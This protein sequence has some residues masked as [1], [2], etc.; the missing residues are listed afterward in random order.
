MDITPFDYCGKT[1]SVYVKDDGTIWFCGNEVCRILGLINPRT[2]ISNHIR[3]QQKDVLDQDTPGGRQKVTI[4]NEGGL[5]RLT[6]RSKVK[7][8]IKFQDWVT[9][10]VL[11][12]I[13]K[14]GSYSPSNLLPQTYKEA[15]Q[16]LLTEVEKNEK[17]ATK[18]VKLKKE[19]TGLKP[20]AVAHDLVSDSIGL[21]CLS[22][23]AKTI[24][25][26][27]HWFTQRLIHDG[28]LFYRRGKLI[29]YQIHIDEEFFDVKLVMARDGSNHS[30][31][32]TF[33]TPK[34]VNY[35]GGI[36]NPPAETSNGGRQQRL[37]S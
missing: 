12:S 15:L 17:L 30:Y 16:H 24:N 7:G 9:D 37:F 14:S 13:R 3:P 25:V 22:D 8:A 31:R 6:L 20:K 26:N 2:A 35:F 23:G 27:P 29:P 18:N 4:I 21:S 34:G 36:Y 32:Q 5:Y 19:N 1:I 33:I 28:Y 10:E 11:P